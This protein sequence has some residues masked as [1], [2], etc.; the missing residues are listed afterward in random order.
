MAFP[1]QANPGSPATAVANEPQATHGSPSWIRLLGTAFTLLTTAGIVILVIHSISRPAEMI[2][3]V[4]PLPSVEA[5]P[6]PLPPTL[7]QVISA[8]VLLLRDPAKV[9]ARLEWDE[10]CY[11]ATIDISVGDDEFS[12]STAAHGECLNEAIEWLQARIGWKG[13]YLFVPEDCD[14]GNAWRADLDHVFTFRRGKLLRIGT[15]T[16]HCQPD[17]AGE[18]GP[19]Y[20][21]GW[22]HDVYDGLEFAMD[23]HANGVHIKLAMAEQGGRFVVNLARTWKLNQPAFAAHG[24]TI[25]DWLRQPRNKRDDFFEKNNLIAAVTARAAIA[26]YCKQ[27]AVLAPALKQAEDF[28]SG[29]EYSSFLDSL[30]TIKPG[31]LPVSLT[32]EEYLMPPP[33]V[34]PPQPPAS[35]PSSPSIPPPPSALDRWHPRGRAARFN[36]IEKK[37]WT[38]HSEVGEFGVLASP[39]GLSHSHLWKFSGL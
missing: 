4:P 16:R 17:D 36:Q 29:V 30:K 19:G 11:D 27:P 32:D 35:M 18:L 12:V 20:R 14:G 1:E 13:A 6:I 31:K 25:R 3:P 2:L 33:P 9:K 8:E 10:H 28:L 21:D 34:P 38:A 37:K 5:M 26:K 39:V 15:I 24:E 23:C 7:S 22:F